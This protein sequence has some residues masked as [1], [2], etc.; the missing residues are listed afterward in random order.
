LLEKNRS[1]EL[2]AETYLTIVFK[3]LISIFEKLSPS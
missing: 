2:H 1:S 3:I